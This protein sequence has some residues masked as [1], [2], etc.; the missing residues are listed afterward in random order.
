[1]AIEGIS[2]ILHPW[3]EGFMGTLVEIA[4]HV[5]NYPAWVL[6]L[7][8]VGYGLTTLV[9]TF[10]TTCI[11]SIERNLWFGYGVGALI[12]AMVVI[13]L[14]MLPYPIWYWVFMLTMLPIASLGGPKLAGRLAG[15]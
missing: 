2:T 4:T 12:F 1:M 15:Y 14:A 13:N 11:G 9:C 5:K 10:L 8:G 7:L 6:A 3:P